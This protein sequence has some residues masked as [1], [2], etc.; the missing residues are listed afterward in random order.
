LAR[1]I[2]QVLRARSLGEGWAELCHKDLNTNCVDEVVSLGT[3]DITG[4]SAR[5]VVYTNHCHSAKLCGFSNLTHHLSR[6]DGQWGG[7]EIR[8]WHQGTLVRLTPDQRALI[9]NSELFEATVQTLLAERIAGELRV[10]SRVLHPDPAILSLRRLPVPS[11]HPLAAATRLFMAPDEPT[12]AARSSILRTL[13][14]AEVD[15]LSH[16]KCPPSMMPTTSGAPYPGWEDCP[17]DPGFRIAF[18]ALPRPGGSQSPGHP[19][20]TPA[21]ELERT[22]TVRVVE[23]NYHAGGG[24]EVSIDFVFVQQDG[25]WRLKYRANLVIIE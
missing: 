3:P 6:R 21:E 2:E 1:E 11:D 25:R 16:P 20:A 5:V 9:R 23:R 17:P 15:S 14:V 24:S 13:G 7:V 4:D 10:E 22:W 19:D 8:E 12:Q 18:I